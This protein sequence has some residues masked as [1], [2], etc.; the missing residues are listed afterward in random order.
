MAKFDE[1][2]VIN[3]LHTD[4]AEIGKKYYFSDSIGSLKFYVENEERSAIGILEKAHIEIV[5]YPFLEKKRN[6][7]YSLIYPC[8]EPE[9]KYVPFTWEDRN[10]LRGKWIK[11]KNYNREY[12]IESIAKDAENL[13][14]Y[15]SNA[16]L[17]SN[18]LLTYYTFL[19]GTPCGK[20]V[21]V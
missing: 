1:S 14:V 10:I 17:G 21:E 18:D 5:P 12:F 7:V 11:N 13:V 15:T 16:E 2:K 6:A 19:D 8:E 4:R 3:A 9:K 20:E